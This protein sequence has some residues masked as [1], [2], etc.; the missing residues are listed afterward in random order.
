LD[1]DVEWRVAVF[2]TGVGVGTTVEEEACCGEV[3]GEDSL[4]EGS[5]AIIVS[6]VDTRPGVEENGANVRVAL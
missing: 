1:S 6:V 5:V 3:A 4:G 2:A